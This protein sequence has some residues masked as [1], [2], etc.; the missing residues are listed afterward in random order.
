MNMEELKFRRRF[1]PSAGNKAAVVTV[2]RAIAQA[3]EQY[4]L[5]ELTFDGDSLLIKPFEER[6]NEVLRENQ[7]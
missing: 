4:E 6:K 3:W 2:P 5:V 1:S 7:A